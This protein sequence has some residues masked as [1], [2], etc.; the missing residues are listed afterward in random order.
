[1]DFLRGDLSPHSGMNRLPGK[2]LR[3]NDM[4]PVP[5]TDTG[6]LAQICQGERVN[7]R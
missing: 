3:A 6:R 2:T 4:D 7:L 5:K 1:M